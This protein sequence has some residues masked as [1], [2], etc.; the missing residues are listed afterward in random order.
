MIYQKPSMVSSWAKGRKLQ[1][2]GSGCGVAGDGGDAGSLVTADHL[3]QAQNVG[4]GGSRLQAGA[5][6]SEGCHG[7]LPVLPTLE[8]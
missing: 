2:F 6:D 7:H 8:S 3:E 5:K 1:G 4:S